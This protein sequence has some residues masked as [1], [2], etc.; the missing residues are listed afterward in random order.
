[1]LQGYGQLGGMGN[2]YW[3]NKNVGTRARPTAQQAAAQ[4]KSHANCS[5]KKGQAEKAKGTK[6]QDPALEV[7]VAQPVLSAS[8]EQI[9][10]VEQQK[11]SVEVAPPRARVDL[12]LLDENEH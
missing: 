7:P 11:E 6:S 3:K 8:N 1:M 12:D 10:K 2:S 9:D 4:G 5:H